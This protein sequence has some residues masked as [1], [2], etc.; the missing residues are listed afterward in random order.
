MER[1]KCQ[2]CDGP[3]V[4]GRCKLCGMP[5]RRDELLYHLNEPRRTHYAHAS[6]EAQQQMRQAEQPIKE[7]KARLSQPQANRQIQSPR[8]QRVNQ[9]SQVSRPTIM[10]GK[11]LDNKKS[12]NKRAWIWSILVLCFV[13]VGNIGS[14]VKEFRETSVWESISEV[15][16]AQKAD[17]YYEL[18][19][20]ET[21][22][23]G[24]EIPTGEYKV[25]SSDGII[26]FAVIRTDGSLSEYTVSERVSR[27]ISIGYGDAIVVENAKEWDAYLQLNIQ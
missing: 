7:Q 23:G 6:K 27:T 2:I 4:N 13:V 15:V 18:G 5:Y 20:G 25:S 11:K 3:I 26:E 10:N 24:D 9:Q 14:A 16:P 22:Q 8:Q 1:K 17:S 21:R 12:K 19:V